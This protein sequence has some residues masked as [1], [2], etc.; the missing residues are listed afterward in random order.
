VGNDVLGFSHI[1][2]SSG[3]IAFLGALWYVS[4]EASSLL[5]VYFFCA[6]KEAKKSVFSGSKPIS[7]A[8]CWRLA[9]FELYNTS[10]S[11][12]IKIFKRMV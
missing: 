10:T 11:K 5:M 4:D 6:L 1:V 9:Q 8:H 7:I 12:A 3:A 2:L